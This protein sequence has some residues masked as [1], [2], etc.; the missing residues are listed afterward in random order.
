[1]SAQVPTHEPE[2][3]RAGTFSEWTRSLA[4]FS[5]ADGWRLTYRI[6]GP[7]ELDI[8]TAAD[9]DGIG[10]AASILTSQSTALPAGDY[11]MFGTVT[12]AADTRSVYEGRL[13]VTPNP[14]A[15]TPGYDGRSH[16]KK[17]LDAL[18]SSQ[19]GTGNT[20]IVSYTIFGERSVTR[21][22]PDQWLKEYTF[23]QNIVNEETKQ[24]QLDKGRRQGVFMRFP[25]TR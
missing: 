24:E 23:W 18:Q 17:M 12:L 11:W 5:Y 25:T 1:L 9:T 14:S 6:V 19:L 15:L 4:D 20:R 21:M 22:T 16:A 13:T 10:F 3:I 2:S 8:S 7:A